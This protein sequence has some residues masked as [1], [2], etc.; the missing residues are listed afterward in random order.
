MKAFRLVLAVLV[1]TVFTAPAFAVDLKSDSFQVTGTVSAMDA[2]SITVMKGKER[3]HITKDAATK[4]TGDVKVGDKV[5][6]H[7]KMYAVDIEA[8]A[9]AKPAK[10]K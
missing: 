1:L 7:Y 3:F 9:E 6:V 8:K 4:T 10:K 2:S 5:T